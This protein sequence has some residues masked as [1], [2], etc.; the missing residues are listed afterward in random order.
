MNAGVSG[1]RAPTLSSLNSTCGQL[2]SDADQSWWPI[3]KCAG[4]A[5][6][7]RHGSA[8]LTT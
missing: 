3:H 6:S 2:L 7:N 1:G 4:L 8:A 5:S